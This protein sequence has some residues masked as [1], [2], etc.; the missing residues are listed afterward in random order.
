MPTTVTQFTAQARAEFAKG[1]MEAERRPQPAPTEDFTTVFPSK[2]KIETHTFMSAL[3][4]LYEFNGYSPA[5]RLVNKEYT[6]SNKEF[7]VGPVSVRKTDLDDDQIGGYLMS[8]KGIPD[9]ARRDIEHRKLA[10][11]AAGTATACFDGTNFFAN[12]HAVG[13]GD[14]LDTF[15][16]SANDGATH[17]IIALRT[18]NPFCKPV[19]FQDRES[20]S[21]LLTDAE[22]PQAAKLKE[23]EYWTDC[24]FGLGYGYW[25]DAYHMTVTDTPTIGEC[26]TIIEQIINGMRTF[27]LPKGKDTDDAIVVHEGWDPSPSNFVLLCNM[28]LGTILKRAMAISQYVTS[29]GNVDNVYKD[30]AKVVPTS[31]L[32]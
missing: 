26:Y 20:V 4:R 9:Q 18:D 21:S 13:S 15:D 12:S 6:V 2:T 1:K 11:L 16:G 17:R 32:N 28:K 19:I 31:A 22:T 5:V 25:W 7:R 14:N 8:V 30:V 24:R 23:F 29:T 10:H 27:T 3:P